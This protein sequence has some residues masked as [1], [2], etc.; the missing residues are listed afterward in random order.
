MTLFVSFVSQGK[1]SLH[2]AAKSLMEMKEVMMEEMMKM[3]M[4]K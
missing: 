1:K 3:M 2:R 4:L